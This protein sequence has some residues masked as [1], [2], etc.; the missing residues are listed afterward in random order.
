M[1][2]IMMAIWY[3]NTWNT[4]HLPLNSNQAFDHFGMPYNVTMTIDERGFYAHEKF[5]EYSFPYL[6]PGMIISYFCFF[7]VYAAV[8]TH[9]VLN[10]RYEVMLGFKS[11]FKSV[12]W[13]GKKKNTASKVEEEWETDVHSRL[14]KVYPEGSYEVQQEKHKEASAMMFDSLKL[15]CFSG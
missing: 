14:M 11:L 8:V 7:C 5:M 13:P 2:F 1:G 12:P 4:A 3:T 9:I 10:H 15:T 6:S